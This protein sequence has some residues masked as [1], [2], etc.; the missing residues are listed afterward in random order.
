MGGKEGGRAP[1]PPKDTLGP[2][3]GTGGG[4]T[5]TTR[6]LGRTQRRGP[7]STTTCGMMACQCP[8]VVVIVGRPRRS[9]ASAVQSGT[10][11]VPGHRAVQDQ[12]DGVEGGR[13]GREEGG[14]RAGGRDGPWQR[15]VDPPPRPIPPSRPPS[16]PERS[17]AGTTSRTAPSTRGGRGPGGSRLAQRRSLPST[18]LS[19]QEGARRRR[20]HRAAATTP[21]DGARAHR[22][23]SA[24]SAVF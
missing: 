13:H 24:A 19:D 21:T 10:L 18:D 2:G 1:R 23:Q 11:E 15:N 12:A 6:P 16:T 3:E 7:Q 20:G 22:A 17:G 14:R 5:A 4:G 9:A 8:I